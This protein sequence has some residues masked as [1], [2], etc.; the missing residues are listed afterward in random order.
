MDGQGD[1]LD[2]LSFEDWRGE[3]FDLPLPPAT[4]REEMLFSFADAV[5]FKSRWTTPW[6]CA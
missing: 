2:I 1:G 4:T 6:R 3:G 5:G